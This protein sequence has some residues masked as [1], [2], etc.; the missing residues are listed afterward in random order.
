[1]TTVAVLCDPPRPG[2]VLQ[3]LVAP[4]LLTDEEAAALYA[5][6]T[7]D[8]V[9]AVATSGAGLLV[10]YRDPG[11]DGT[12]RDDDAVSAAESEVRSVVEEAIDLEDDRVRFEVQVGETF[13]GRAGN[14]ATH[15][16]S[17]EAAGSVAITRPEAAFLRRPE[18]DGTAMKLRSTDAVVGPAPGGRVYFAAFGEPIDFAD[19]YAPPSFETVTD[20]CLDAGLDVEFLETKPYLESPA[21]LADAIT[22]VRTVRKAG[23]LVPPHLAEWIA[24]TDIAVQATDDGLSIVR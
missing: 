24:E 14:T 18:I 2:A 22:H 12:N 6:M 19:A 8:V 3:S 13:S 1:M 15:L 17:T 4:A 9:S 11:T 21:D 16:L 10:N 20:R 23:G 5:A 7:K